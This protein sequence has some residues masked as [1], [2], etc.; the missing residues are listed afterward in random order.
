MRGR[1]ISALGLVLGLFLA[2]EAAAHRPLP[3]SQVV[4]APDSAAALSAR[5]DWARQQAASKGLKSGYWA[6]YSIRRMMGEHSTIGSWYGRPWLDHVTIESLI[7]PKKPGEPQPSDAEVLRE[8]ARKALEAFERPERSDKKVWKDIGIFLKFEPASARRSL[9]VEVSDLKLAFDFEGRP[10][11]WLGPAPD[12]ESV[13]LLKK[14]Y[15]GGANWR[16]KADFLSAISVHKAPLQVVPFM[17]GVLKSS[18]P[19]DLRSEAASE[20][21]EQ[22]D[23]KAIPILKRILQSDP[24]AEVREGAVSGLVEMTGPE[25]LDLLIETALGAGDEDL[26]REAIQGLAEKAAERVRTTMIRPAFDERETEVQRQAV[27][28]LGD[29]DSAEALPALARLAE[30]HENPE[31]R[32]AA[33]EALGDLEDAAAVTILIKLARGWF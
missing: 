15:E 32:I 19:A 31:V 33:I 13:A 28:A 2:V 10:L 18:A 4:N 5:L 8:A 14:F 25:A 20:I 26:R 7:F 12:G 27:E 3:P 22:D 21:G 6:G 29:L 11:Y 9:S 1:T 30:T 24:S 16:M 17:E 23:P